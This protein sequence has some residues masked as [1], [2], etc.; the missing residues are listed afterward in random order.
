MFKIPGT[1]KQISLHQPKLAMY[2]SE[3]AF[4]HRNSTYT[5]SSGIQT[6]LKLKP[7]PQQNYANFK[8]A[9]I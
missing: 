5:G 1:H 6:V 8:Q 7:P 2:D 4:S 3:N 9:F